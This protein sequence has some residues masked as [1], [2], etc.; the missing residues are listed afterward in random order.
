MN[1][2]ISKNKFSVSYVAKLFKVNTSTI[3]KWA[4]TFP[5]YLSRDANPIKGTQRYFELDDIRVMSHIYYYWEDQPDLEH[6]KMGLNSNNHYDNELI[7]DLILK[8]SPFFFDYHD[9]M[10]E[11]WNHGVLFNGLSN[12]SDT[13]YLANSYKLAG[14]RLV[15]IALKN[16][17]SWDLFCPAVYNYRHAT[18]LY[19]KAVIGSSKQTHNLMTLFEKFKKRIKEKYEQDCPEWFINI[20]LTFDTFDPYGTTFRY[21]GDTNSTEIFNDFIQMKTAMGWLA[22]S[23]QNIRRHQGLPNV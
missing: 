14:D 21:G 13:F 17:E 20:V 18:E 6:I 7:D 23:F 11:L 10:D 15:D 16:E 12:L 4:Q 2:S 9:E 8:M 3:K 22:E 1:S 5:E 19:L